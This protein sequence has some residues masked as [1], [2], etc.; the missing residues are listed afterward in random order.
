MPDA[1]DANNVHNVFCS[2][3]A[4]TL[5]VTQLRYYAS[6]LLMHL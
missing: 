1:M 2:Y 4:V 6:D 5:A 3:Y